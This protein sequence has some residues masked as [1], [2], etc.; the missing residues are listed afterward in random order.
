MR[1][2]PEDHPGWKWTPVRYL[3]HDAV[4]GFCRVMIFKGSPGRTTGTRGTRCWWNAYWRE[5]ECLGCR[6]EAMRAD[7]A[8]QDQQDAM[9]QA[10][11]AGAP[12]LNPS[13][14]G[15]V[16][17]SDLFESRFDAPM[18]GIPT[19]LGEVARVLPMPRH[20]GDGDLASSLA[21]RV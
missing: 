1:P 11:G 7:T 6:S 13:R 12:A 19:G 14:E 3:A 21:P 18:H 16:G 4:C 9:R 20:A 2:R 5:Y 8:W 15:F 17:S 10:V